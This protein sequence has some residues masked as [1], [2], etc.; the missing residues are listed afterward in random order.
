[1]KEDCKSS[2]KEKKIWKIPVLITLLIGAIL[3]S[4]TIVGAE[5]G[6]DQSAETNIANKPD[7]SALA[8]E[9]QIYFEDFEFGYNG[10]SANNGVWEIGNSTV[11]PIGCYKGSGCVGTVLNGDYPS[12]TDSAIISPSIIL[13]SV[14]TGEEMYL[15]FWQWFS[16]ATGGYGYVA[17][18]VYNTTTGTWDDPDQVS[19]IIQDSSA[20][21]SL[22][23]K[24]PLAQFTGKKIK[25]YFQHNAWTPIASGWTI[26]NV[27]IIKTMPY[28]HITVNSPNGG[29]GWIAGTKQ[30]I[31]WAY[32]GNVGTKVRIDLLK[33]ESYYRGI[34]YD[35]NI[36]SGGK[37]SY[38]WTIPPTLT[39][40]TNYKI[41]V[42]SLYPVYY[43]TSDT[44]FKIIENTAS[45]TELKNVTYKPTYI[46][47]T[48]KDP[49][50][51]DF[52]KVKIYINGIF[53]TYVNK[54][55]QYYNV[56]G[57]KNN[58]QYKI[59]THTL[60]TT[61]NVNQTWVNHTAKTAR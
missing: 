27:E 20:V 52:S 30:V 50:S 17:I 54:G 23:E 28:Q 25:I 39:H 7:I 4:M 42:T 53:K 8:V 15:R 32:T 11:N 36:G 19:G 13:P 14:A 5:K 59:S 47:W 56:T 29:E 26:D 46:K 3:V 49:S 35:T 38:N 18:S 24:Y 34:I 2:N 43:D 10:W 9:S 60:D 21:W 33:G 16:Y 40:G 58:T 22:T 37:G 12:Y 31:R 1:M 57:L 48:W 61:G 45:I 41:L 6:I 44:N 55:V 51:I